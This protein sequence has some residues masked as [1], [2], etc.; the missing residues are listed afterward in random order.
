MMVKAYHRMTVSKL[1][2]KGGEVAVVSHDTI[3][4]LGGCC[5][6]FQHTSYCL[7]DEFQDEFSKEMNTS[8]G[9]LPRSCPT[10]PRAR[11][12]SAVMKFGNFA[13]HTGAFA[14]GANGEV[15]MG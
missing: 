1:T 12:S 10:A 9:K 2:L 4:V 5:Y 11:T 13:C 7:M 8:F 14:K 3:I 6:I 15:T